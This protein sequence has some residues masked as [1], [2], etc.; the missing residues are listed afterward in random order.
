MLYIRLTYPY[1]TNCD[2]AKF[3]NFQKESDLSKLWQRSIIVRI[4]NTVQYLIWEI[5]VI[6]SYWRNKKAKLRYRRVKAKEVDY[7]RVWTKI[8]VR[9]YSYYHFILRLLLLFVID[10]F[11]LYVCKIVE[12]PLILP[13]WE[14]YRIYCYFHWSIFSHVTNTCRKMKNCKNFEQKENNLFHY[15]YYIYIE[16]YEIQKTKL[17]IVQNTCRCF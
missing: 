17:K 8:T 10:N 3:S 7:L 11:L 4:S 14:K 2:K 12:S 15:N 16:R 6:Y 9:Y 1:T 5:M 13:I